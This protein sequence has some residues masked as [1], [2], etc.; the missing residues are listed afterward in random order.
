MMFLKLSS[1]AFSKVKNTDYRCV[2]TGI[3]KSKAM[4]LLYN[5]DS[6]EK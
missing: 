2:I 5:I 6:R 4:K 1:I 3:S